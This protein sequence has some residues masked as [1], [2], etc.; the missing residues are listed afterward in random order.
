MQKLRK[1]YAEMWRFR[2]NLEIL[3]DRNLAEIRNLVSKFPNLE[4]SKFRRPA[5]FASEEPPG[6]YSTSNKCVS[7]GDQQGSCPCISAF[8]KACDSVQLQL[9]LIP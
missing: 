2:R 9:V 1:L 4:L 7:K 5:D 3:Y 6:Q 8:T